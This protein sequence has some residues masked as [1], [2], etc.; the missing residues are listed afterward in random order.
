[1]IA[2]ERAR[3]SRAEGDMAALTGRL[4][5]HVAAVSDR[6]TALKQLRKKLDHDVATARAERDAFSAAQAKQVAKAEE[7]ERQLAEARDTVRSEERR[8]GEERGELG[9]AREARGGGGERASRA[10]GGKAAW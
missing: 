10:E 3:A 7:L 8:V 5:E 2:A 9:A 4:S 6:D 1:A